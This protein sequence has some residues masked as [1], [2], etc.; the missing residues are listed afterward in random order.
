MFL[1]LLLY[2]EKAVY[3]TDPLYS[4]PLSLVYI[5]HFFALKIF[6][7]IDC[8]LT[9]SFAIFQLLYRLKYLYFIQCQNI[10]TNLCNDYTQEY[11]ND[12]KL[13]Y[14]QILKGP[15]EECITY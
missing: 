11:K 5:T 13:N 12:K 8:Y 4:L 9:P 7:L 10:S 2:S 6:S 3:Y 1:V 15:M 14:N